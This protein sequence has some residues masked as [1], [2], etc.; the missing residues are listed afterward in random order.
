[1]VALA[2]GS[3]VGLGTKVLLFGGGAVHSNRVHVLETPRHEVVTEETLLGAGSADQPRSLGGYTMH[4]PEVAGDP[5]AA[6]VPPAARTRQRGRPLERCSAAAA[7][8]MG[9]FWLVLGGFSVKYSQMNDLW[10]GTASSC[11]PRR[12]Q[13]PNTLPTLLP[14]DPRCWTWRTELRTG[15]AGAE[16]R[17]GRRQ[18]GAMMMK[19]M[20]K[21]RR[22]GRK[23]AATRTRSGGRSRTGLRRKRKKAETAVE[24]GR[25]GRLAPPPV[26]R[27]CGRSSCWPAGAVHLLPWARLRS[28]SPQYVYLSA[29][30][31]LHMFAR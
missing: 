1:M 6:R 23:G 11:R 2:A 15:G 25:P 9:R 26:R 24:A 14:T 7:L 10:V 3:A 30:L 16:E 17:A 19:M 8:V 20:G 31:C 13:H 18:K 29:S 21:K 12:K 22:R 4:I 28:T 5:G 27:C